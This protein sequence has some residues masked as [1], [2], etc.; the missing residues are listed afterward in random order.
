MYCP[1]AATYAYEFFNTDALGLFTKCSRISKQS[2]RNGIQSL[3]NVHITDGRYPYVI[4][5][6]CLH[7]FILYLTVSPYIAEYHVNIWRGVV[8][9]RDTAVLALWGSH[10]ETFDA[11]AL[12]D[13]SKSSPVVLLFVGVTSNTFDGMCLY[14]LILIACLWQ[15][16]EIVASNKAAS[17]FN[18]PQRPSGM[19][20]L[21]FQR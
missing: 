19:W 3:V 16:S 15:V 1:Y 14:D 8:F 21:L 20:I 12:M 9:F 4:Q 10:A 7:I 11:Q 17:P 5:N 6:I 13:R 2:T 18:A